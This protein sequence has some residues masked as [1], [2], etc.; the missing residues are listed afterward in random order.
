MS[1]EEK[2]NSIYWFH[3]MIG[4]LGIFT[5]CMSGFI[6]IL[7]LIIFIKDYQ[8]NRI[9][10]K[11]FKLRKSTKIYYICMILTDAFQHIFITFRFTYL[12]IMEKDVRLMYGEWFCRIHLFC[13]HVFAMISNWNVVILSMERFWLMMYPTSLYSINTS[14][15]FYSLMIVIIVYSVCILFNLFIFLP[16]VELCTIDYKNFILNILAFIFII[17]LPIMLIVIFTTGLLILLFKW[18]CKIE[19]SR[20]IRHNSQLCNIRG[21]I[22]ILQIIIC[23]LLTFT[24]S[25]II[26]MVFY[27]Q[28][29][30]KQRYVAKTNC[31]KE[32]DLFNLMN[33]LFSLL[34]CIRIYIIFFKKK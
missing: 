19:R 12:V 28:E 5:L 32:D 17:V 8:Q 16:N 24:I 33:I 11:L 10:S 26:Y 6:T 7:W 15:A 31:N 4:I 21:L 18:K 1:F 14:N 23:I 20:L 25:N 9:N 22:Q 3:Y 30:Y 13:S 27:K 34:S 29:N 2:Y